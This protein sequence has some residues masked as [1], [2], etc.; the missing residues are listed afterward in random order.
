MSFALARYAG[1]YVPPAAWAIDTQLGQI[2]S[3]GDCNT[4]AGWTAFAAFTAAA[5]AAAGAIVSQ[6]GT[7]ATAFRTALF[8]GRIAFLLGLCFAFALA[9]QGAATVLVSPCLH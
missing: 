8:L 3:Y 7:A 9:L 4:G 5:F 1:L 2:L 6:R